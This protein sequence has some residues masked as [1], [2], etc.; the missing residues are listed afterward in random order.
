MKSRSPQFFA[1]GGMSAD[2]CVNDAPWLNEAATTGYHW[3]AFARMNATYTVP[4]DATATAGSHTLKFEPTEP[5]TDCGAP[6][7]RP[8]SVE[9]AKAMPLQPIHASYT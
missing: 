9:R 4:S 3:L 2:T 7:L 1:S 5:G 8:P 6:K